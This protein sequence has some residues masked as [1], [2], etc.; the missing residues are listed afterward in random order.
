MG[1]EQQIDIVD[2]LHEMSQGE[3]EGR[4][5]SIYDTA[6][7][8]AELKK[9][10]KDFAAPGGESQNQVSNRM[11]GWL[12]SEVFHNEAV[13]FVFTHGMAISCV[14]SR[15]LG[16]E[17]QQETLS[18]IVP[19]ASYSIITRDKSLLWSATDIIGKTAVS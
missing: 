18:R 19:N 13:Y 11:F 2:D 12:D 10:G 9:Y 17:S 1:L 7:V 6:P 16:Y 14:L 3:W 8:V 5:R 4:E 15:I